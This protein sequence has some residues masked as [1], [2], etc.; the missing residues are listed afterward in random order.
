M[1]RAIDCIRDV[2]EKMKA[3]GAF[4]S[5]GREKVLTV[6]SEDDLLDKLKLATYPAV[7]V[8]YEGTVHQPSDR[9]SSGLAAR[10]TVALVLILDGQSVGGAN[11]ENVAANMLDLM[12]AQFKAYCGTS[13]T[14][15]K[16]VF[17]SELPV[18]SKNNLTMYVQR[19]S[20]AIILS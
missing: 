10:L 6:Y 11:K 16:W 5:A 7:G 19:W 2:E 20:T 8:M 15:H 14:G 18:G 3:T 17:V 12:R 9:S 1:T 13:Q 4:G